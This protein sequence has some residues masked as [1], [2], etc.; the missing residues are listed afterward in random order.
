MLAI[1]ILNVGHG[2][3][4]IVEYAPA[5][6]RRVFGLID[7]NTNEGREPI[8]IRK[9]VEL[10]ATE[11]SFLCI[12]HPHADHY[13]GVGS[14]IE[15]FSGRIAKLFTFPIEQ[16][17]LKKVA[18][19]AAAIAS[20]TDSAKA[21]SSIR[22]YLLLLKFGKLMDPNWHTDGSPGHVIVPPG[23]EGV[24][25]HQL[26]PPGR[27]RGKFWQNLDK[28]ELNFEAPNQNDLSLAFSLSYM[29]HKFVLGGDGTE[30]NWLFQNKQWPQM[31]IDPASTFVKL[32][33][34]G[35]SHDCSPPVLDIIFSSDKTKNR[36]A[37]ISASGRSHPADSVL[38]DLIARGIKPY[39][40]NLA[41]RCGAARSEKLA[42]PTCNPELLRYL[43]MFASPGDDKKIQPCQG[44]ITLRIEDDGEM[45]VETEHNHPCQ[46]RGDY[47]R[48]FPA[49]FH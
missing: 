5:G 39:C 43:T 2:D 34:H 20:K 1:H 9:L 47:D 48:L 45:K 8:A 33:H 21:R 44:T 4:I 17:K 10:G 41:V 3:S 14:I 28:G 35:S 49:S 37:F 19:L 6:G 11:L 30:E 12:T 38:D 40:T 16:A 27:V 15:H 24:A 22:D 18:E 31:A 46:F 29:G 7:T 13:S 26:L 42:D 36:I 23:F 25:M 32:P